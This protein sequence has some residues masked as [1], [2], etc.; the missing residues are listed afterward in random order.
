MLLESLHPGAELARVQAEV[1]W[2][3]KI[4]PNLRETR[5]PTTEELRLLREELDPQGIYRR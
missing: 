5:P 2:E 1:G 3:L 4:A